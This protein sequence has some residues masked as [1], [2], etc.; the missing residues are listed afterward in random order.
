MAPQATS[1]LGADAGFRYTPSL[2]LQRTRRENRPW[3]EEEDGDD[4]T[5][6]AARHDALR[7]ETTIS[8]QFVNRVQKRKELY[9][10]VLNGTQETVEQKRVFANNINTAPTATSSSSSWKEEG[11]E[12]NT[13]SSAAARLARAKRLAQ[14]D[15]YY[16]KPIIAIKNTEQDNARHLR[17][18]RL[19]TSLKATQEDQESQEQLQAKRAQQKAHEKQL[20]IQQEEMERLR[21]IQQEQ[22]RVQ[23]EQ[24]R[25]EAQLR[26]QQR[27]EEEAERQR[28]LLLLQQQ[29]E[30]SRA[31]LAALELQQQ[32]T[33]KPRRRHSDSDLDKDDLD[34]PW[35]D[36][37]QV[38]LRGSGVLKICGSSCFGQEDDLDLSQ[39][40]VSSISR[41]RKTR[42]TSDRA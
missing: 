16:I 3:T 30:R 26:M 32:K 31:A 27:Q 14:Q 21:V 4:G 17:A 8:Q 38:M 23:Q 39:H 36:D 12:D 20:K 13:V 18:E 11:D 15:N 5:Q 28:Q 24:Q 2:Y 34:W 25:V 40:S 29:E 33:P 1:L 7:K 10:A 19:R 9:K 42:R 41:G 6:Q 35:M 22:Q 37:F